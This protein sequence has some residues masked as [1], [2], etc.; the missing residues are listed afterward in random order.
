MPK[1]QA[2]DRYGATPGKLILVGVLAVTALQQTGDET[3]DTFCKTAGYV[4]DTSHELVYS[5]ALSC[6]GYQRLGL[7]GGFVCVK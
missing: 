2:K 5:E 3:A 4:I 6:C 7:G 1:D